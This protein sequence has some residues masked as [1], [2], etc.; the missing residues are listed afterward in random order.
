MKHNKLLEQ[1][2]D[3]H[4]DIAF[5]AGDTNYWSPENTTVYYKA[6]L[7]S[8]ETLWTLLHETSHGL[9]GHARYASD[10]E[11]VFLEVAAWK[12]AK[13][14]AKNYGITI[15]EDYTQDC[16]DSYRDWQ[17]ARSLCPGCAL[18]GIQIQPTTYQC[19]FCDK[20]WAVTS[21]RFC[22]PYRRTIRDS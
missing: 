1:L 14:L 9:L 15:N 6:Q 5:V 12:H 8:K 22:R 11:L 3:A 19:L 21:A 17:H 7:D 4:P 2:I 13:Q 10:F 16:L 18:G 20:K